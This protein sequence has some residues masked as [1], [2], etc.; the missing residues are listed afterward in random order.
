[1]TGTTRS[2]ATGGRFR[3]PRR[4]SAD[5][6]PG[7]EAI[8]WRQR[9]ALVLLPLRLDCTFLRERANDN[10]IGMFLVCFD[11]LCPCFG[12]KRDGSE[13]PVLGR[14]ANSLNSSELRSMSD[15][16]P[17]SPLR[18]HPSPSRFSLSSPASRNE[19]L[20]LSLEEVIK[21]T[22][23]FA[24]DQ[25]I[26][27]GYFGKEHFVSLRAEFSNEIALLKKIEHMNLVQLLGY[28]DKRNERIVITE[29][30]SNGTLRNHL[31]GQRGIIL[32]FS[33]RLEIAIDVAH[34]LTYLHLY[35]GGW[36]RLELGI[37]RRLYS[38]EVVGRGPGP[39]RRAG[40][41]MVATAHQKGRSG[42]GGL[43]S[44]AYSPLST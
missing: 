33:Q 43:Q 20:N 25:M 11:A 16:I 13:D 7:A 44:E 36:D 22:R 42:F 30:V 1:M 29:Y 24:P 3:A 28:I 8:G 35:A 10:Q 15:R 21:L 23:N 37:C 12:S 9:P 4:D 39:R 6:P 17:S 19:P 27:E 14:D 26:G 2:P 38:K 32:G 31:D 5:R 34:G 41:A 18:V 40:V